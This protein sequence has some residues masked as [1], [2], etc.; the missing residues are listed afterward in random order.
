[1]IALFPSG[2]LCFIFPVALS[3][4]KTVELLFTIVVVEMFRCIQHEFRCSHR[5][6][7]ESFLSRPSLGKGRFSRGPSQEPRGL[8]PP[9]G[10]RIDTNTNY[11]VFLKNYSL[12][13]ILERERDQPLEHFPG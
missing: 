9:S 1:M 4:E 8:G 10:D 13:Y 3:Q 2:L 12:N 7:L 11:V 5:K 6:R